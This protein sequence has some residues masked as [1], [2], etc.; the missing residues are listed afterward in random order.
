[1]EERAVQKNEFRVSQP[2]M[3]LRGAPYQAHTCA[4]R[5]P[6]YCYGTA[7]AVVLRGGRGA[8][9]SLGM[10]SVVLNRAVPLIVRQVLYEGPLLRYEVVGLAAGSSYNF[11]VRAQTGFGAGHVPLP[12]HGCHLWRQCC[13]LCRRHCRSWRRRWLCMAGARAR[14][15]ARS[16]RVSCCLY[17]ECGFLRLISALGRSR[18]LRGAVESVCDVRYACYGPGRYNRLGDQRER[19]GQSTAVCMNRSLRCCA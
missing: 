15:P 4:A 8:A 1:M 5:A 9:G 14:Y 7:G 2:A 10:P 19:T 3:P 6:W 11:R 16:K 13:H 12:L 17:Q 18:V